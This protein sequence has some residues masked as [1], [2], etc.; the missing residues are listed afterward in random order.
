MSVSFCHMSAPLV[1]KDFGNFTDMVRSCEVNTS[2]SNVKRIEHELGW[3]FK[4]EENGCYLGY[5]PAEELPQ[6][7]ENCEIAL[8]ASMDCRCIVTQRIAQLRVLARQA[9]H[10]NEAIEYG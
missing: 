2:Q 4:R 5:I 6:F 3:N 7:I 8:E 10:Y 9:M 1:A